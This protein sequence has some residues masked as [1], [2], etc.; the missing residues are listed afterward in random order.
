MPNTH[1]TKTRN[2]LSPSLTP[3][4]SLVTQVVKNLPMV[5]EMRVQSLGR[6]DPLE[7]GMATHSSILA[8]RIPWTEEPGRLH[9][10][11]S[12]R[13]GHDWVTSSSLWGTCSASLPLSDDRPKHAAGG[14][15]FRGRGGTEAGEGNRSSKRRKGRQ[16]RERRRREASKKEKKEEPAFVI[17]K[18]KHF[19]AQ[20]DCVKNTCVLMVCLQAFKTS[21]YL[22]Q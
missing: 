1:D 17:Q 16:K 3:R 12:Q 13:A 9:S 4:A 22:S 10:I 14:H 11:G 7:K 8:W 19:T 2:W 18:D 20:L 6:G 5:Q 15:P 21:V